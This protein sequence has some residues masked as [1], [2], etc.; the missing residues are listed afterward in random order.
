MASLGMWSGWQ[1]GLGVPTNKDTIILARYAIRQ[2]EGTLRKNG[3]QLPVLLHKR[4]WH[5]ANL[6][7]VLTEK[8]NGR[9]R[10]R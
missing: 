7:V 8:V 10:R 4:M 5:L 6:E 1:S 2:M 9:T 3:N